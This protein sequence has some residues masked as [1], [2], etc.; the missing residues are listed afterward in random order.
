VKPFLV[1]NDTW[2]THNSEKAEDPFLIPP[3]I[4]PDVWRA[5]NYRGIFTSGSGILFVSFSPDNRLNPGIYG[6]LRSSRQ[7]QFPTFHAK[8]APT[9]GK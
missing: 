7:V 4:R 2:R 5:A 8:A 1:S 6:P 9:L 3:D